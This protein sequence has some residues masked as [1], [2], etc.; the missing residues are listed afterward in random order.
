VSLGLPFP[1]EITALSMVKL[2]GVA[3]VVAL[4]ASLAGVRRALTT[5]PALAFGGA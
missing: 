3:L 5:D 1:A 4:L 2:F